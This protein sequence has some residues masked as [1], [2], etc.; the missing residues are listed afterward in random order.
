MMEAT[1]E[2][3]MFTIVDEPVVH[4]PVTVKLPQDGSFVEYQF[5]VTM[6]VLS[7][8]QYDALFNEFKKNAAGN[9]TLSTIIT[10]T[11]I[12]IDPTLNELIAKY[13][14]RTNTTLI[15][16]EQENLIV[17]KRLITDW[18]GIRDN[19]GSS[20]LFSADKL[21]AQLTGPYALPLATGLWRAINEVRFGARLGNLSP[22]SSIG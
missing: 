19:L 11:D 2:V 4:W 21:A 1:K 3:P 12:G 7:N 22:P 15:E 9:P 17:F 20:V 18:D 5:G 10:E 13:G 16:N 14:V 6:K 8:T